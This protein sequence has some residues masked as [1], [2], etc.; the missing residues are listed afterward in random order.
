[1]RILTT[2]FG[3]LIVAAAVSNAAP[4]PLKLQDRWVYVQTNLA[5][6]ANVQSTIAV[7]ERAAKDGYNGL[8]IDDLKFMKWDMAVPE[9]AGNAR[10]VRDACRRLGMAFV[11]LV[12]DVG[13]AE[14]LLAHDPNLAA[15]LPVVN[16]PFVVRNGLLIPAEDPA[17]FLNGGFEEHKG[18]MPSDWSVDMPGKICFIDDE[19]KY[20]GKPSLRMQDIGA[21]AARRGAGRASQLLK[22]HPFRNYHVSVAVK[23][24]DFE[25]ASTVRIEVEGAPGRL[26]LSY[27]EPVVAK[28]QDWQRVDIAFNSLE[29]SQAT[30]SLV[31][32]GGRGG[33]GAGGGKIWWA[34]ARIEP[35]G[36]VNILR[37]EGT[38]L[39]VTSEDGK[40]Q[41]KEGQDFGVVRD[42]KLGTDP[43]AGCVTPWHEPPVVPIPAGSALKEGQRVL[44]SYY[45]P[46]IVHHDQVAV[47]MAEPK[48]YDL[49]KWQAEQVR[50][51]LEPDGY[52][53]AHDEIRSQGWDEGSLGMKMTPGQ[54]LAYNMKRC[55]E[56]LNAADPGKPMYV[57]SDMFD[58]FHNAKKTGRYYY[59]KGEGPWYGSW[60][61]L[62][63]EVG[64]VNWHGHEPGRLDSL[65]FFAARG[66][67]QILA[68]YYDADPTR[69]VPWLADAAQVEGV[70][71]VM[72][73]TW[74]DKYADLEKF[75]AELGSPSARPAGA[76]R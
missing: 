17:R 30:I 32:R 18:D 5:Q 7:L 61:G 15:G 22:V 16:A 28:T 45:H 34:D 11:P 40:T 25:A 52:F 13:A 74:Q 19:V 69:I 46:A 12:F 10:K 35:A 8:A 37:R 59:V 14:G 56:I 60:E 58:P 36:L 75:A 1:V 4:A 53:M 57:W 31:A 43:Y 27:Y 50:K 6:E 66:H 21:N 33:S 70:V 20:E 64:I 76:T 2:A 3:V 71:G 23:T 73:T 42:P 54:I 65:K 51:N 62:P 29:C 26:T 9:Y 44:L 49:L 47:C 68:G 63:K 41:Y 39:R 67:K 38:P 24:Q 72:Y 48:V 55:V